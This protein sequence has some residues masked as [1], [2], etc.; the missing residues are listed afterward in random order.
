MALLAPSSATFSINLDGG[1]I[2]MQVASVRADDFYWL[3]PSTRPESLVHTYRQQLSMVVL[4]PSAGEGSFMC[5]AAPDKSV[6]RMKFMI[7]KARSELA[8]FPLLSSRNQPKPNLILTGSGR[9]F[10]LFI[11]SGPTTWG[12]ASYFYDAHNDPRT[13]HFTEQV[14][15]YLPQI[16]GRMHFPHLK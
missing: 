1:Q 14:V 11:K 16:I 3:R 7:R 4:Y 8:S 12:P 10:L 15:S 6:M 2:M 13:I 5:K 9:T